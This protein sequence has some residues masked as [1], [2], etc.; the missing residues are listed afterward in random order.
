MPQLNPNNP[1]RLLSRAS[2]GKHNAVNQYGRHG[3]AYTKT[4]FQKSLEIK[5]RHM[6]VMNSTY[7]S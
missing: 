7:K 3:T 1:C 6:Q 5:T 4:L 2:L